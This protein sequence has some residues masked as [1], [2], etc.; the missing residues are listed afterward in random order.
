[1]NSTVLSVVLLQFNAE[2]NHKYY[3]WDSQESKI[4]T[5]NYYSLNNTNRDEHVDNVIDT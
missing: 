3:A 2:Q 4:Y 5:R 1:M